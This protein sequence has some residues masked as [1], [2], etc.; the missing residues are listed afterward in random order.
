VRR[1]LEQLKVAKAKNNPLKKSFGSSKSMIALQAQNEKLIEE[2]SVLRSEHN[3]DEGFINKLK[4]YRLYRD[5]VQFQKMM[6][7]KDRR[8]QEINEDCCGRQERLLGRSKKVRD[9]IEEIVFQKVRVIE[10][11]A[12]IS[13]ELERLSRKNLRLQQDFD[14]LIE[15]I[16][17]KGEIEERLVSS[18]EVHKKNERD[19]AN[20]L[21][22]AKSE[23]LDANT[24]YQEFQV[25][26]VSMMIPFSGKLVLKKNQDDEYVMELMHKGKVESFFVKDIDDLS[27]HPCKEN[28]IILSFH[29]KSR[30]IMSEEKYKIVPRLRELMQRCIKNE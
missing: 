16:E 19:L 5:F 24:F 7:E 17:S 9:E 28:R 6:R 22:E 8:I 21:I 4:E 11:N 12:E 26:V 27:E 25:K 23:L 15:F 29:N 30:D 20:L 10:R 3:Q 14:H 18:V 2:Y 13:E 1:A